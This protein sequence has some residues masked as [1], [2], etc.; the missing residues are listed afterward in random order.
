MVDGILC[1]F[2]ELV[3][4]ETIKKKERD[5]SEWKHLMDKNINKITDDS[6]K[7]LALFEKNDSE[8][9]NQR[10]LTKDRAINFLTKMAEKNIVSEN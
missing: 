10:R 6:L 1:V 3:E 9:I 5:A 8:L 2:K 4:S 7:H